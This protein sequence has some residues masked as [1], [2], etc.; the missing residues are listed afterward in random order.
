MKIAYAVSTVRSRERSMTRLVEQLPDGVRVYLDDP[1]SGGSWLNYR[2]ALFEAGMDGEDWLVCLDDDAQLCYDFELRMRD[3]LERCPGDF[4][5]FYLS[6]HRLYQRAHEA[7]GEDVGWI[8]TFRVVHGLCFAIRAELALEAF[9]VGSMLVK[10]DYYS[11]D[12]RLAAWLAYK[13]RPNYIAI[14][15]LVD[16]DGSMRS[17]INQGRRNDEKGSVCFSTPGGW[18]QGNEV[19]C[20]ERSSPVRAMRNLALRGALERSYDGYLFARE[21]GIKR[22]TAKDA[23]HGRQR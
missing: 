10:D 1:P 8:A 12:Q 22:F 6:N 9:D 7:L 16:H 21:P 5:T 4:A 11:G 17:V 2:S 20:D 18:H 15:N 3:A 19:W 23:H 14:P 13:Q